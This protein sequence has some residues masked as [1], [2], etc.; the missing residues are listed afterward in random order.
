MAVNGINTVKGENASLPVDL[1]HSKTTL[2]NSHLLHLSNTE[3]FRLLGKLPTYPSP[4]LT[5]CPR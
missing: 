1:H 5:F 2:L 4:K 3:Q